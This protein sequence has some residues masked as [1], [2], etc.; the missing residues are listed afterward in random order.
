MAAIAA[1]EDTD[2]MLPDLFTEPEGYYKPDPPPTTATHRMR[3]G[4]ELY[5]RLVGHDPLWVIDR[6][7]FVSLPVIFHPIPSTQLRLRPDP[8]LGPDCCRLGAL[9]VECR[10]GERSL[11]R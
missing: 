3:S 10:E 4:K 2:L 9:S 1:D 11:P 7:P 6:A 8:D 5:L